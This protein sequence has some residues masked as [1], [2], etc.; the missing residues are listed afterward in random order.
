MTMITVKEFDKLK[1]RDFDNMGWIDD[2]RGA[3]KQRERLRVLLVEARRFTPPDQP[4][5]P[6]RAEYT[7]SGRIDAELSK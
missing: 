5:S 4:M 3:L 6:G 7:I 1:R 2:I